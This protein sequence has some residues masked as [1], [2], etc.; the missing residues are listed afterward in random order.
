M[1]SVSTFAVGL[2]VSAVAGLVAPR[3]V[4]DRPIVAH[5]MVGGLQTGDVRQD[6]L[7]AKN[8]GLDGFALN[9]DQFAWWSNDTV[10]FMFDNADAIGGFSLF[11]SFDHGHGVL[12]SP[13]DYADYF[14]KYS[15]RSSYLKMRDPA[16]NTNKPLL[17]T[18]G[19]EDFSNADWNNFKAKVGA[20]L[21]VPGFYQIYNPSTNFFG[22]RAALDGVFNWNSWPATQ[23]G[24]VAVSAATDRTFQT[25]AK[26]ANKLFMMGVSPVQYKHLD[27]NNNWYRRGEDNLENRFGQVLDL[28][29]N[30]VQLQT[31]N[32]AGEGHYMGK[33]H[34][35]PLD[36][37]TK[38]LT[39]G[40]DH[41]GYWQVLQPFIAAWKR[42]DRTTANMYPS[43]GK[44]VQGTFWHH[45]LTVGGTCTNDAVAK[46]TDI[47]KAAEDAV[48]G[49]VLVPK[50]KTNLVAVVNVGTK[51]LN[52]MTLSPGYNKFKF[53][54][55]EKLVPGKV[56]LEVWDGS[57]MVGGGYG[58]IEVTNSKPLCNYQLQ[59]V[60]VPS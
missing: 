20:V 60:A 43:N 53:T 29:P 37:R 35:D 48:S 49:V 12:K 44:A 10:N 55:L 39:D 11:F 41:T 9:F 51:Q 24:K 50:G 33:L 47:A 1:R 4:V 19:G 42:G 16:D 45:T 38:L 40:Y 26:N 58:S 6:I 25:S 28:Q 46:S 8:I 17:S 36:A 32:D 54:G 5:Y 27:N 7:D 13:M 2:M 30:M 56:Q 18:F 23:D 15:T 57:T 22:S 52:K 3:S 14:K 21:V 59:V 34:A 31:W